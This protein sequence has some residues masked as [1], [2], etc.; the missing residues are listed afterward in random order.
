MKEFDQGVCGGN[1]YWKVME[2]KILR[3]GFYCPTM[4]SDV[5]KEIT[6]CHKC[7]IFYGKRKLVP[8]PL[9]PILVEAPSEQRG[10]DFN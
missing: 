4:F 8:L 10:L 7:Q 6:T 3:V 5:Y 9:N 2:N 1:H